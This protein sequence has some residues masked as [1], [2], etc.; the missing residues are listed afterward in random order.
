MVA[1][2]IAYFI[3]HHGFGHASRASAVM[4][5]IHSL[6]PE[7][8]FELFTRAPLWFFDTSLKFPFGYHEITTD[9]GLI[10]P[11]PLA[12]DLPVTIR[13]LDDFL[14][15]PSSTAEPVVKQLI[16]MQFDLCICDI[17]P[18]GL[19]ASHT[20]GIPSVLIE[21]FTWDWIYSGYLAECPEFNRYIPQ[22]THAFRSANIHIQS[23]PVCQYDDKSDL[24]T[25]PIARAPRLLSNELR[26]RLKIPA[27]APVVLITMGGF[28]LDFSFI[29][30][31]NANRNIW[32]VIP[33]GA[34]SKV[35]HISNLVL[36]PH[37]SD[38]YHPD[39]INS[40][41]AVISKAGYSTI[42]EAYYA[43]I[44]FGYVSRDQFRESPILSAFIQQKMQGFEING[45]T[46]QTGDWIHSVSNLL[47]LGCRKPESENGADQA[48]KLI[49]NFLR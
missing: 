32:F 22:F 23:E 31:L 29:N 7:F 8:E 1:K 6:Q 4:Q 24:L 34:Q 48:A 33:G 15:F 12:E 42:A 44:P 39:L 18:F 5:A 49:V 28:E 35:E 14:P 26:R 11:T 21:N 13:R 19:S 16:Q 25:N 30:Q 46:F 20:A 41:N 27:G 17:S 40:A 47:E 9:V 37:H 36:L 45:E 10:Q 3:S 43:G 2:R 38:F